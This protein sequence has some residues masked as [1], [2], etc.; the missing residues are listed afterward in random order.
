MVRETS[1]RILMIAPQPCFDP[2][3]APY[4]VL[5]QVKALL[6]IGYCVDLVTYPMGRSLSLPGLSLFR[7]PALPFVHTVKPGFSLAK[8]PLDFLVFLTA[9]WRL[10]TGRYRYLHTH[11]EGALMGI[12]LAP[13]FH[14]KHLYYMHCDLSQL[15]GRQA[16]CIWLM[17]QVQTWMVRGSDTIVTFYPALASLANEL[18]PEK[19]VYMIQPPAL[20]ED[21]PVPQEDEL[22]RVR[23]QLGLEDGPVVLYTGTL[24]T[25]QGLELLLQSA[26][27][28]LARY[29]TIHYAIVG[30]TSSQV[31]KLRALASVLGITDTVHFISQRPLE[32]MPALMAIADILVS[33]RCSGTHT[34]LKIY[35]YLHAGKPI[36][37]TNIHSHTQV[38]TD[39]SA[40][41]VPPTAVDLAQGT[42]LLLQNPLQAH[43]L[44]YRA[45]EIAHQRHSWQ[46]FL[47]ANR[48]AH[49]A[50]A[51]IA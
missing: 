50:F 21:M 40:L 20:D 51:A 18:A 42:I 2:R 26:Q 28:V 43:T 37:A 1:S 15:V 39:E 5:Q 45:Q 36:L 3:G 16:L 4:C 27:I 22:I 8:F 38:L 9:L 14:C 12:L 41:L 30:G 10:C 48:V 46:V 32:E 47:E 35:T 17:K 7:A 49:A 29:P 13:L 19:P 34:P 23:H 6:A 44:G 33:P 11:E 31:A 24:E 25:Y